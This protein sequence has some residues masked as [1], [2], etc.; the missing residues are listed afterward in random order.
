MAKLNHAA[1]SRIGKNFRA[2]PTEPISHGDRRVMAA[3]IECCKCGS[4]AYYARH[5]SVN[6]DDHFRKKGWQVGRGPANDICPNCFNPKPEKKPEL[7]VVSMQAAPKAE[8]PREMSREERRIITDKLDDVYDD[9][10]GRYKAPWTDTAVSKD[11]GVPR[12]WVSEVR[13]QFFGPE[14]S[15]SDFDDFLEKS[16]PV[17]ADMKN[18]M[19]ALT[20]QIEVVKASERS[21]EALKPRIEEIERIGRRIEKELGR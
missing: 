15:N 7:K 14:G 9:K 3:K 17:I 12:A 13:E 6:D 8:P 20:G 2:F 10:A 21:I 11:L 16:A 5:G 18:L 1:L 19:K 4:V